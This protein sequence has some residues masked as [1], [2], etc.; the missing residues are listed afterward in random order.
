MVARP[1]PAPDVYLLAASRLGVRPEDCVVVE[2]SPAGA[3]SA[4]AAGMRVI[5]YVSGH[6]AEDTVAAMRASGAVVIR[7]MA[8]LLP[9][10]PPRR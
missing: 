6:A 3:A 4:L 10:I 9:L 7:S 8:E 1:K 2:D 5:G